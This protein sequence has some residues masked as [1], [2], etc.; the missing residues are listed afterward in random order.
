[1]RHTALWLDQ[2]HVVA[3]GLD[4]RAIDTERDLGQGVLHGDRRAGP[5][6]DRAPAGIHKRAHSKHQPSAFGALLDHVLA[7][8]AVGWVCLELIII[9]ARGVQL[10]LRILAGQAI[11]DH[12][13]SS[14]MAKICLERRGKQRDQQVGLGG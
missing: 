14:H 3:R 4:H 9:E 10:A 6:G 8:R 13:A 2:Q 7:Q 12:S 11:R 5:D 1:M